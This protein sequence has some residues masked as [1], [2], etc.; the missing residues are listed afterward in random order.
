MSFPTTRT[1]RNCTDNDVIGWTQAIRTGLNQLEANN[2]FEPNT[3]GDVLAMFGIGDADFLHTKE[4]KELI[5]D[6]L[7]NI[8]KTHLGQNEYNRINSSDCNF[9][10]SDP[11]DPYARSSLVGADG[12]TTIT[13]NKVQDYMI[14]L[15]R[16]PLIL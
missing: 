4:N 3:F 16:S 9:L 1:T 14:Y 10:V 13:G 12:G 5:L 2:L 11:T 7:S 8:V 6:N 15:Y